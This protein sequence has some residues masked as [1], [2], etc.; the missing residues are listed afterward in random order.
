[1]DELEFGIE[2][3][4]LNRRLGLDLS[5]YN[6]ATKDLRID[7]PLDPSTGYTTTVTNIGKIENKG[8]EVDLSFIWVQAQQ[9]GALEWTSNLNWSTNS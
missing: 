6:K 8:A 7:R 5:I 1:M 2:G 9:P 3:T 4:F